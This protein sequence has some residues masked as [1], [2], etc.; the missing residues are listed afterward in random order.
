V[1]DAFGADGVR[2]AQPEDIAPAIRKAATGSVPTLIH[3][4]TARS[5]PAD[6]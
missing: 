4:P 5:N 6:P 2:V 1:A 3:V